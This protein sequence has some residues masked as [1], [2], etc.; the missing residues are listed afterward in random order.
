MTGPHKPILCLDFDGVIH[1]YSKGWQDGDIY[2]PPTEGFF[3]WL[4]EAQEHFT[5]MILSSRSKDP[6]GVSAM[7]TW[8]AEHAEIWRGKNE[9]PLMLNVS[10]PQKKPAAFL[11]IDDR[12]MTF[13]GDWTSLDPEELL[14]FKPWNQREPSTSAS[15]SV[16]SVSS[17]PAG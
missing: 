1:R 7:S 8:L 16:S 17:S 2:D 4:I 3:E 15:G 6:G 13:E 11:S 12:A 5:I 9:R 14:K 10:F